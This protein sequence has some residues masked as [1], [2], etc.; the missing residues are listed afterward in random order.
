MMMVRLEIVSGLDAYPW[1][2]SPHRP[3][4]PALFPE[5]ITIYTIPSELFAKNLSNLLATLTKDN[6]ASRFSKIVIYTLGKNQ[7]NWQ[8]I[9][10]NRDENPLNGPILITKL[11]MQPNSVFPSDGFLVRNNKWY[12]E[13][14]DW[15]LVKKE[16][17]KN[18]LCSSLRSVAIGISSKCTV[19]GDMLSDGDKIKIKKCGYFSMI[20]ADQLTKIW[21]VTVAPKFMD[22]FSFV[23][24]QLPE[25]VFLDLPDHYFKIDDT[26]KK[27]VVKP[28]YEGLA[29]TMWKKA[30]YDSPK[31]AYKTCPHAA[32]RRLNFELDRKC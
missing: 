16:R 25:F 2:I 1:K 23:K 27:A 11:R 20:A 24:K 14:M 21:L 6:S 19:F 15:C 8:I 10:C 4:S 7:N 28:G 13:E 12:L 32:Q 29:K 3:F 5:K 17:R 30:A 18:P 9:H 22:Q 31:I 26:M